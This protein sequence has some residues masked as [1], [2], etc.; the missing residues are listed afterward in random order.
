MKLPFGAGRV[1]GSLAVMSL[2]LAALA[3]PPLP[4]VARV[5]VVLVVAA[6]AALSAR[7]SL[8]LIAARRGL[9]VVQEGAPR[10][11][12]L[13]VSVPAA[14]AGAVLGAPLLVLP[15]VHAR[16][17]VLVAGLLGALA[18][19]GL[20][21]ADDRPKGPRP[22]T[23]FSWL[24]LDTALPA[25]IV[26]ASVGVCV[27]FLRLRNLDVVTPGE[28]ARHLGMTT[29][30]YALLLGLAGFFKA[31]GEQSAGLVVVE[32]TAASL[33]GPVLAGA[34]LGVTLL[35]AVPH[36]APA[37]PLRD[38]LILKAAV[39]LVVGGGLSLLGA[40]QGA[41]AASLGLKRRKAS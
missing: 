31:Y 29:F 23:R 9:L 13:L 14:A 36:L 41:R 25:G 2:L 32:K 33:P 4:G 10:H 21:L 3:R 15:A 35:F 22:T 26:A 20:A 16:F 24:V 19:A 8:L 40:L 30:A 1:L 5:V 27:A 28:L 7:S 39:G 12:L 6:L 11:R 34:A 18:G 38:A 17:E 37:L